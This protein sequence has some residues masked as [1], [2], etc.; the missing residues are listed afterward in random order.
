VQEQGLD[1]PTLTQMVRN[2][3]RFSFAEDSVKTR[4]TRETEEAFRRFESR[5]RFTR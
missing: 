4:L 3:I 1:Y 2:S 5:P